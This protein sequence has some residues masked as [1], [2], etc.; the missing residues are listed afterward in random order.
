MVVESL[1]VLAVL[2]FSHQEMRK[3]KKK[4]GRKTFFCSCSC[5]CSCNH[6]SET[7]GGKTHLVFFNLLN[8]MKNEKINFRSRYVP[9]SG[10]K[11]LAN[12]KKICPALINGNRIYKF[13]PTE[14]LMFESGYGQSP[15]GCW[16]L[17]SAIFPYS[18]GERTLC[19]Y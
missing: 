1:A 16:V 9:Q 17:K 19:F 6:Q 12:R 7:E 11:S 10:S 4:G 13:I 3:K 14:I 15:S 5:K 2:L 8:K 18:A